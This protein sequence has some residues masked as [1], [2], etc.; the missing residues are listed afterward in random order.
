MAQTQEAMTQHLAE[1]LCGRLLA[2]MSARG[3]A[4][5]SEAGGRRGLPAGRGCV[6]G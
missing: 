3:T 1:R 4:P 5:V 2:V 6:A